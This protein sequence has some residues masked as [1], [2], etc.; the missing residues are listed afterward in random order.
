MGFERD[1][2]MRQ[3]LMLFEVL[4]MIFRLRKKGNKEEALEQ[5]R[6]FYETLKI[7]ENTEELNIGEL[8]DLLVT[9]KKFNN[10]QLEI[11]AYVL[12]EQGE[13]TDDDNLQ[14]DYF[15]KSYFLF[16]KVERESTTFSMDRLMK[17]E[18]LKERINQS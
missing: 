4:Q 17:L 11:V 18:E 14:L 1:Y 12:K 10:E 3:L 6:I 7:E 5:V 8:M 13:L 16:E 2:L 15:Y 9:K